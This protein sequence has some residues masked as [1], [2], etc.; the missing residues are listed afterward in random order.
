MIGRSGIS[1]SATAHRARRRCW[2]L[3]SSRPAQAWALA[4]DR[5]GGCPYG[6]GPQP[7]GAILSVQILPRY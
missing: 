3:P 6:E 2:L 4:F 5:Y 7:R 1:R